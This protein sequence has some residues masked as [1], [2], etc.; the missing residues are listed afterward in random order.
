M[1]IYL[2]ILLI[3]QYENAF[4]IGC[5]ENYS[6]R[7]PSYGGCLGPYEY[8]ADIIEIIEVPTRIKLKFKH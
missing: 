1:F 6:K 4:K 2:L 7:L 3:Q 5:T 8:E